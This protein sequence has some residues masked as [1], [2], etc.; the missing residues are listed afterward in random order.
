MDT[1]PATWEEH[2]W[3]NPFTLFV[4]GDPAVLIYNVSLDTVS[5]LAERKGGKAE[6]KGFGV[7]ILSRSGLMHWNDT[8]R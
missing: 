7:D 2:L 8:A 5:L 4:G 3:S 1:V 6:L